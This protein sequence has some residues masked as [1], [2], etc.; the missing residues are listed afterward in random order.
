MSRP[1]KGLLGLGGVYSFRD[2]S[3]GLYALLVTGRCE[4]IVSRAS[5]YVG[6][7]AASDFDFR[8]DR[9]EPIRRGLIGPLSWKYVFLSG[10]HERS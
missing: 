5:G 2:A 1:E 4:N 10:G 7:S 9:Y 8:W 6:V 3:R